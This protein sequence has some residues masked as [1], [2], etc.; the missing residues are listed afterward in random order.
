MSA[1]KPAKIPD[2]I[3][4]NESAGSDVFSHLGEDTVGLLLV[5]SDEGEAANALAVETKLHARIDM[6]S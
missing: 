3:C 2:N 6:S 5:L 4:A 1:S